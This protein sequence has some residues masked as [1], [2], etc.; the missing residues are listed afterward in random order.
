MTPADMDRLFDQLAALV[1]STPAAERERLLMRLVVA[2]AQELGDYE[3]I[4][5][6]IKALK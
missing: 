1:D 4:R 3:K 5:E 6:A 2:L